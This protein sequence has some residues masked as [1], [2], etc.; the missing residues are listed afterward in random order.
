MNEATKNI[1]LNEEVI[2][3]NQDALGKQAVR[4]IK[5]DTLNVFVKPLS[6]GDY[7]IAFLNR[8]DA[9][10]TFN[11]NFTELGLKDKYEIRDLW[12]H[13]I[14]SKGKKWKGIVQSH[15]TKMFQLVKAK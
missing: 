9:I 1:L 14:I 7:A 11:I 13:K 12:E 5:N 6:N 8:S 4:V 10:Q 15:E 2:A 3:I